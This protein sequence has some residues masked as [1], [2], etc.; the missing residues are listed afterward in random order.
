MGKTSENEG[1]SACMFQQN[2]T[3]LTLL[4][5]HFLRMVNQ[6]Q[7]KKKNDGK[8][9]T[10]SESQPETNCCALQSISHGPSG[11]QPLL[12]SERVPERIYL[13]L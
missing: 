1:A 8:I 9:H 2:S 6:W 4:A 5:I 12:Q 11:R 7:A 10:I 13:R 3:A